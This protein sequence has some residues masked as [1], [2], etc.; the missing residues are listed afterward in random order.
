MAEFPS[1]IGNSKHLR[2]LN[3]SRTHIKQLPDSV[4]SLLNLHTLILD[5]CWQLER[6]PQ[7]MMYLRSLRHLYLLGC[8]LIEMPPK[9]G[10]LTNLKT[11]T[12]FVVGKS[13]DCSLL[14]EL[15]CLNLGGE[16]CIKHLMR[17]NVKSELVLEALQPHPNLKELVVRGYKGTRFPFWMW[18]SDLQS[19]WSRFRRVFK[20]LPNTNA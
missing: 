10:Q 8:Q 6:L 5:S 14:A 9:I 20:A 4:C 15:K 12:T 2:Y 13:T 16:L 1:S 17:E 19:L 7:N 3:L 18:G 11:L